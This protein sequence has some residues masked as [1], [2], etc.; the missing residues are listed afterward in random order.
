[1]TRRSMSHGDR[2]RIGK[3]VLGVLVAVSAL[4]ALTAVAS[5]QT[6]QDGGDS[7]DGGSGQSQ[8]DGG[9][10]DGGTGSDGG[11][12]ADTGDAAEAA[13]AECASR[14]G[15]YADGWAEQTCRYP[16]LRWAGTTRCEVN[17]VYSR[18][19]TGLTRTTQIPGTNPRRWVQMERVEDYLCRT[20]W[21]PVT[22]D[23]GPFPIPREQMIE[24]NDGNPSLT[25]K[26]RITFW[27]SDRYTEETGRTIIAGDDSGTGGGDP[28]D[29]APD[30]GTGG[31]NGDS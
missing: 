10:S 16:N 22:L 29:G 21:R 5:A 30:S 19:A 14:Y 18:R 8:G 13:I 6:P 1:M 24:P 7:G 27:V 20:I 17:Q 12:S 26:Y 3:I 25:S 28:D 31:S 23:G 11:T 9:T 2:G 15:G 4:F